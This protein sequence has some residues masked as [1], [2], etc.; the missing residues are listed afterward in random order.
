MTKHWL[1]VIHQ[2]ETIRL[3]W[4]RGQ[5][6]PRMTDP[7]S[8]QHP[9][10]EQALTDIRWY[11][12]EYLRF[13][14]GIYPDQATEIE[15]QF[16]AW[17]QQLFELV[18]RS[19]E[20]GRDFFQEATRAGLDD[21]E[22]GIISDNPT[23]L[24]LPWELLYSPDDLFLAPKLA[25]IY[26]TLSHFKVRAELPELP[27]DQLNVLLIIARPYE[28]D[29]GFHTIARPMVEALK[30]I[31]N[32]V[33]LKVLRPPSFAE[34][35]RELNAHK[36]GFYHIVHFDGHGTF[37]ADDAD[38]PQFTLRGS[39]QGELVFETLDGKPEVVTADRIAQSLQDCRVPVFV[40]N[41]CKSAQEGEEQFSSVASRLVFSG[42][43]G[44]VAMAYSVYADAAREFMGRFYGELTT[45]TTISEAVA[46]ARLSVLNQPLRQSPRGKRQLQDWLVPILYQ[47]ESYQPFVPSQPDTK[48][49]AF[50]TNT[51]E[52]GIA[53]DSTTPTNTLD[54]FPIL[55]LMALLAEITKF[56]G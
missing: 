37:T 13:P 15:H 35:E 10:N 12:E 26:R 47:R 16:Q 52:F 55:E 53:A 38:N 5:A 33:N 21:C 49:K 36:K 45:G 27:N 23:I 44:V 34:F 30:P 1:R 32:R 43:M 20:K 19:T 42:A 51:G 9:F 11:L 14:Y 29:I 24:N 2:D 22:L 18:F 6:T 17:G 48:R 25:G 8:F 31:S 41:A 40:L 4:Q 56:Y 50:W 46:K 7:V 3:S 39:G 54:I 28:R